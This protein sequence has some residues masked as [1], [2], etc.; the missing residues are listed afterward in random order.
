MN[1]AMFLLPAL[2][3]TIALAFIALVE[4]AK[5]FF[6][7]G[8]S[9]IGD[10]IEKF[11]QWEGAIRAVASVFGVVADVTGMI[12]DGWV[13]IIDLI[14]NF[15]FG[16]FKETLGNM[17]G[18][19]GNAIG[20]TFTALVKDANAF[21]DRGGSFID[22]MIDKYPQWTEELGQSISNTASTVID[23][24]EIIIQGGADT[25]DNIADAVFNV[26]QQTSQDLTTTVD[27]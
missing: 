22:D 9:F 13:A 11:P 17:P 26:F 8:E 18:L 15:S 23:R 12:F 21:F 1:V 2:I 27:Q 25:A 4:D 16:E 10:M 14:S 19:L 3:A 5:V 7:G 6:E 24:M 20:S